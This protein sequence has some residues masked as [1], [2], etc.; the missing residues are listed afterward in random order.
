M[1]A[2]SNE[3]GILTLLEA[4][5]CDPPLHRLRFSNADIDVIARKFAVPTSKRTALHECLEGAAL[6]YEGQLRGP[7]QNP[8]FASAK[9]Y[10]S[11]IR[12][13]LD[14]LVK[15]TEPL[16]MFVPNGLDIG[17]PNRFAHLGISDAEAFASGIHH[18]IAPFIGSISSDWL[19]MD[20]QSIIAVRDWRRE[21]LQTVNSIIAT[22]ATMI[23]RPA[24]K[25]PRA[26]GLLPLKMF[27]VCLGYFWVRDLGR[28][29][30][31]TRTIVETKKPD[32]RA[33]KNVSPFSNFCVTC[34][35]HVGEGE[36]PNLRT[37]IEA[38]RAHVLKAIEIQQ[39]SA[40]GDNELAI[41]LLRE[42]KDRIPIAIPFDFV[43][44]S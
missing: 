20:G 7:A 42:W 24:P 21:N 32:D 37:P 4:T 38:A 43:P 8:D 12:E 6:I 19:I 30:A 44:S 23:D 25:K 27:A 14:Q 3:P 1:S 34:F 11:R 31:I 17:K 26:D 29:I 18:L 15:L 40:D 9:A 35:R 28:E 13:R 22:L 36:E 41:R 10:L 16:E 39:A 2:P 5:R 33:T